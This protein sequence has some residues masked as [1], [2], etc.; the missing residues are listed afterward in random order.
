MIYAPITTSLSCAMA[1]MFIGL[2]IGTCEEFR[3]PTTFIQLKFSP[4]SAGK[5]LSEFLMDGKVARFALV[6]TFPFTICVASFFLLFII[7]SLWQLVGPVSHL[8]SNS[9]FYSG[10]KPTQSS[11][12][13]P[14]FTIV[15]PVY[16]ESLESVI[17]PTIASLKIAMI[18]Y[19]RQG[20][21]VRILICE[22]GMQCLDE[23][24]QSARKRFYEQQNISWV[25]RPPD[26]EN[27][28]IRSVDALDL[29]FRAYADL[30]RSEVEREN[31]RRPPT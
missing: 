21:T 8:K 6:A 18:A 20:G 2:G 25:A 31:L 16:K 24:A 11:L 15:C 26:G 28:F 3:H 9:M 1:I 22:D 12:A 27:G 14:A 30:Q 23:A 29:L 13:L 5:L 19:E 4:A 7:G 17:K 10:S